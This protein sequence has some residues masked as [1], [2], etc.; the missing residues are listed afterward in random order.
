MKRLK[1]AY[2]IPSLYIHGGMER[3]VTNKANYLA[4]QLG[5][6]VYIIMT[7]A[8]EKKPFFPISPL[9]K[10]IQLDEDF[11]QLWD[12]PLH[13]KIALYLRLM[14]N[15]KKKLTQCLL[16]IKPDITI[17]TLR[18]EINFL[19]NI[20][21]GS[22]KI[23]ELHV[24]KEEFRNLNQEKAA[25]WLKRGVQRIWKNQLITALRKLDHFVVLTERDKALW[26]ELDPKKV[27]AIGNPLS[28][29]SEQPSTC[30]SKTAV[31]VGRFCYQK[32]FDLL[33]DGWKEVVSKHPDWVLHIYG[34]NGEK[35]KNYVAKLGLQKNC[36]LYPVT[37][38]V[39]EALVKHSIFVLSSRFEGF[40]MVT[41]EA[42]ACGV[43]PVAFDCHYGPAEIIHHNEDGLLVEAANPTALANGI[44][45]LIEN[46]E[47]RKRFGQ[48][49]YKNITRYRVDVIGAQWESLFKKLVE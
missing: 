38:R 43:P 34:D 29:Y 28:F 7:D 17:S 39:E 49:G 19:P 8:K 27:S 23:G 10:L 41:C 36:Q 4:D 26:N 37:A 3:V 20:K 16:E 11:E 31:A 18:R 46:E 14:R 45:Q 35:I 5:H 2:C 1:I 13:Q 30:S 40:G 25:T 47:L 12:K 6:E 24:N 42:M 21:D 22:K 33:L 44:N 9:V 15:Y 48:N 32:G